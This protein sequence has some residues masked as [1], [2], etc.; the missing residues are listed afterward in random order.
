MKNQTTQKTALD[1]SY[2][3]VWESEEGERK[4]TY[5]RG[6]VFDG[7]EDQPKGFEYHLVRLPASSTGEA[8]GFFNRKI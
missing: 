7:P 1:R 5:V 2:Y 4:A 6:N 3:D 8:L